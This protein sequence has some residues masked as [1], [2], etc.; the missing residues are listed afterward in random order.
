MC[1][2]AGMVLGRARPE[3]PVAVTQPFPGDARVVDRAAGGDPPQLVEHVRPARARVPGA[4]AV[5]QVAQDVDLAAPR[6]GRHRL[7][8]AQHPALQ[9][10]DGPLDLAEGGAGQHDM[11][12]GGGLGQE[13]VDD[14]EVLEASSAAAWS[15]SADTIGLVDS[16]SIPA[17]VPPAPASSST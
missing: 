17:T 6:G 7:V 14:D 11:G 8:A 9:G 3:H 2:G 5:G 15:R 13:R 4:Q 12:A 10:G 16:R 1:I